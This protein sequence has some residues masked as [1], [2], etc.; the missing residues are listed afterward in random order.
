MKHTTFNKLVRNIVSTIF[1]LLITQPVLAQGGLDIGV[2]TCESV[3]STRHNYI[4]SSKTDVNCIFSH[5]TGEERYTGE[6]G[7]SLGI[8]L[9]Q[10]SNEQAVFTVIAI[11]GDTRPEAYSLEGTYV[12]GKASAAL[13]IGVGASVML[14]GGD[15]NFSLQP[16]AI[17]TSTG[18]GA[19]LGIGYLTLEQD[20]E[21]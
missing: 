15:K 4:F 14:G 8:D 16:V 19:A 1:L 7:M 17:E 3:P 10:K 5:S 18:L 2:L 13:I 12:G 9:Q 11:S 20:E 6:M 21:S